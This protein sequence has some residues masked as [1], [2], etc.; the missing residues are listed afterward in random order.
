M[1]VE[2]L[3]LNLSIKDGLKL[4]QELRRKIIGVRQIRDYIARKLY[5]KFRMHKN[6]IKRNNILQHFTKKQRFTTN[7][8]SYCGLLINSTIWCKSK[9]KECLINN[10]RFAFK[11]QLS[12]TE[13]SCNFKNVVN[14]IYVHV[15][16]YLCIYIY[17]VHILYCTSLIVGF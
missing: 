10:R 6:C 13:N 9:L 11:S 16:I 12:I 5:S 8:Q 2:T 1:R 3:S 17:F 15:Y 14:L 7:C 4:N